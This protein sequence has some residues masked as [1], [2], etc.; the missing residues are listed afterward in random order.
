MYRLALY[1]KGGI[2]KSTTTC[3][4][5][6]ALVSQGLT[7]LQV[8]C[9]PKSDSTML[10]LGGKSLPTVL[11]Q[12]R[13]DEDLV[14][15]DLV[16]RA[17][18]GVWCCE[19]GGPIPGV[20]CAGRGIITA[21]DELDRL[22]AYDEINPD[23]VLYD[24]LGDVVCGGFAM[25]LRGQYSDGVMVVTSGEMMSLYAAANIIHAIN[26]FQKRGYAQFKGLIANLRNIEGEM[27]KIDQFCAEEGA[28]VV[29]CV[30]RTALIQEAEAAGATVVSLFPD[31]D[32][33]AIYQGVARWI[34]NELR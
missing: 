16:K 2:G 22:R 9:D 18:D 17:P 4:I 34:S 1:G 26:G 31:S 30:P 28:S 14:L 10:H 25:P 13:G 8:G 15:D 21:F 20:G 5:A 29:A 12:M 3:N 19:A 11:D 24:V 6:S 23:V 7:V 33:S 27:D 32:I